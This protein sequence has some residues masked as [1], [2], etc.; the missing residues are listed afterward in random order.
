MSTD[1]WA[2]SIIA[3]IENEYSLN[4]SELT[5]GDILSRMDLREAERTPNNA[6]RVAAV[7]TSLG[8]RQGRKTMKGRCYL[9]P[10]SL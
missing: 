10:R 4:G 6:K 7:L 3:L 8:W 2:V 9:S 1:P 5:P